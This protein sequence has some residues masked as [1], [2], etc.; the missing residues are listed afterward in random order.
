MINCLVIDDEPLARELICSYIQRFP[1]LKVVGICDNALSAFEKI[2]SLNPDL[3]FLDINMPGMNGL[4]L[5]KSLRK[6]PATIITSAYRDHAI[7]GFDLN[8]TDFL[9][10]PILF[11]RF[12]RAVDKILSL[13]IEGVAPPTVSEPSYIYFRVDKAMV[14]VYLSDIF[15]IESQKDYVKIK[16]VNAELLTYQRISYLQ[17]KLPSLLFIRVHR[18]FIVAV[19]KIQSMTS[20]YINIKNT[21]IPIG[22]SY[23]QVIQKTLLKQK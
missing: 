17:E 10:K 11:E 16:T 23:R 3:I 15:W 6:P 14:K 22:Q 19:D 12:V 18:S 1:L 8:V 20:S 2:H 13:N 5:L 4:E 9:L 21:V 7:E